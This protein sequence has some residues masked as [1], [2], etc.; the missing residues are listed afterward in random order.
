MPL[1]IPLTFFVL[2]LFA[3][4]SGSCKKQKNTEPG[5]SSY[6]AK[7]GGAR[8]WHRSHYYHASGVH[9]PTPINE[10]YFLPDTSFALTIID[11]T[12]IQFKSKTFQYEQTDTTNEIYFFGSAYFF[13]KYHVGEGVAYYYKKDSIVHCI[14]DVHGTSDSWVLRDL[15]YTY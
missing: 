6:T 12:T 5:K 1:K 2:L 7:M 8:N 13:Y 3:V 4:L 15:C 9:F 14:G 11:D 10:S